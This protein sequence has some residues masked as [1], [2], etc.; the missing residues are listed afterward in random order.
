MSHA[1]KASSSTKMAAPTPIPAAA[2]VERPVLEFEFEVP[3]AVVVAA[4]TAAVE[5]AGKDDVEAV[6]EDVVAFKRILGQQPIGG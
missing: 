2:P 5:E 6:V 4:D 3:V 1:A